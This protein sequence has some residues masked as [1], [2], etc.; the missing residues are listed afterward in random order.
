L[1]NQEEKYNAIFQ[2]AAEVII[3][4]DD[5]GTFFNLNRIFNLKKATIKKFNL[6]AEKKYPELQLGKCFF[7]L[8]PEIEH[9]RLNNCLSRALNEE[10]V[11][12]DFQDEYHRHFSASFVPIGSKELSE[13]GDMIVN[14]W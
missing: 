8:L 6:C 12:F 14:R 3:E 4:L 11:Q 1:H 7:H 13:N 9:D 5:S 10:I 2:Q